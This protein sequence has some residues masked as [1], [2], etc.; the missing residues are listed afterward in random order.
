SEIDHFSDINI[1]SFERT[2]YVQNGVKEIYIVDIAGQSVMTVRVD[3]DRMEIP[4]PK[5]GVY[6]V[7]TGA[8]TAKVM[9]K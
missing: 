1:W 9:V 8:K 3:S 2:I 4:M 7:K 6:V 5:P